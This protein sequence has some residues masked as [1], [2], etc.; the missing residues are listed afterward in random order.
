MNCYNIPSVADM[1]KKPT[2]KK[3]ISEPKK[4]IKRTKIKDNDGSN[5]RESSTKDDI[6]NIYR[7]CTFRVEI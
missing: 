6:S 3:I 7:I 4:K 2:E 5:P 1:T